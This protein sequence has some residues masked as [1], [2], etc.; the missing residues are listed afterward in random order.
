MPVCRYSCWIFVERRDHERLR[1]VE[2]DRGESQRSGC[3]KGQS[4]LDRQRSDVGL[5]Q[6]GEP[7]QDE[8]EHGEAEEVGDEQAPRNRSTGA[9]VVL[10][11][12]EGLAVVIFCWGLTCFDRCGHWAPLGRFERT[13]L[14]ARREF[15][16]RRDGIDCTPDG[17]PPAVGLSGRH[18]RSAS[19]A[20]FM[21][22]LQLAPP[23]DT[24][25]RRIFTR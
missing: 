8:A 13:L 20:R 12:V 16:P 4:G 23:T 3:G 9:R 14:G 24:R 25:L 2:A 1:A 6:R 21:T 7:G 15:T 19:L 17:A 11:G 10:N 22:P 18:R 5:Y